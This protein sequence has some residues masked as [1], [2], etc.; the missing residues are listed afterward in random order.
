MVGDS[1]VIRNGSERADGAPPSHI[2]MRGFNGFLQT[3]GLFYFTS[4]Y[5]A[6]NLLGS[7]LMRDNAAE[8]RR[9]SFAMRREVV[10]SQEW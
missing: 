7:M 5:Q 8:R 9:G 1:N 3:W 10:A 4:L 6:L 2:A